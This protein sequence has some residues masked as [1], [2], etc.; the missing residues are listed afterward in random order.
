M[1]LVLPL[2]LVLVLLLV[3]AALPEV[4]LIFVLERV[5]TTLP[6]ISARTSSGNLSPEV[7]AP[8]QVRPQE[9]ECKQT[10]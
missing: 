8:R 6:L 1:P 5:S 2:V 10:L 4:S 7:R 3:L 9:G